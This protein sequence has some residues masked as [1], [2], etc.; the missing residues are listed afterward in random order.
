[1]GKDHTLF[2]LTEGIVKMKS[3]KISDR[4]KMYVCSGQ[5]RQRCLACVRACVCVC[6]H[7]CAHLRGCLCGCPRVS[8]RGCGCARFARFGLD[9][10]NNVPANCYAYCER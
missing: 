5:S 6:V 1:M 2:A 3:I 7:V 4:G 8:L 9:T 10:A